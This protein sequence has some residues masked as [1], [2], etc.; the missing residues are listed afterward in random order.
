MSDLLKSG[1]LDSQEEAVED[2]NECRSTLIP[3]CRTRLM[4]EDGPRL[5]YDW[6]R[7]RRHHKLPECPCTT[8]YLIYIVSKPL[9]MAKLYCIVLFK[10]VSELGEK[11]NS[12]SEI[13]WNS[14]GFILDLYDLYSDYDLWYCLYVWVIILLDLGISWA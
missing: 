1:P 14:I 4:P 8:W 6:F 13:D 2:M 3:W 9:L 5:F 10:V 7:A 12:P 11:I